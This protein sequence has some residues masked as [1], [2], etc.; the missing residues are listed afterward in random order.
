MNNVN[1][2]IYFATLHTTLNACCYYI[3]IQHINCRP[4]SSASLTILLLFN[5]SCAAATSECRCRI[6]HFI[7]VTV[8]KLLTSVVV[9]MMDA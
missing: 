4:P 5:V 9:C 3:F 7:A 8:F 2:T 6:I 1:P